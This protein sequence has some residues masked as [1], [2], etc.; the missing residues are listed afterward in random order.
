MVAHHPPQQHRL[1]IPLGPPFRPPQQ[2]PSPHR[3]RLDCHHLHRP[4]EEEHLPVQW[5]PH[6]HNAAWRGH[7][8]PPQEHRQ[9][10]RRRD[11]VQVEFAHDQG[12]Q[13]RQ[14]RREGKGTVEGFEEGKG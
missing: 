4:C 9:Q 13:S 5:R 11:D 1:P 8:V 12:H 6:G 2:R 10:G 14:A 7:L 3:L